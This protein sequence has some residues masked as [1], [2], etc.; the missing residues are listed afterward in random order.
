MSNSSV[1][2]SVQTFFL[3]KGGTLTEANWHV[4]GRWGLGEISGGKWT[5]VKELVLKLYT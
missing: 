2:Y 5:L 3:K 1:N 4:G